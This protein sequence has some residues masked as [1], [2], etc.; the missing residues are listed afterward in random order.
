MD[1]II[2]IWVA[3]ATAL[4]IWQQKKKCATDFY[5][6][7]KQ[8]GWVRSHRIIR[9]TE[10]KIPIWRKENID[11][12]WMRIYCRYRRRWNALGL[13]NVYLYS[14]QL[15]TCLWHFET[16]R[17][18]DAVRSTGA[19]VSVSQNFSTK[20]YKI[21]KWCVRRIRLMVYFAYVIV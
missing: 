15:Y 7:R 5:W 3:D 13:S 18:F 20:N 10:R 17:N 4:Q 11:S 16:K 2:L 14:V 8:T 6:N 21:R 19:A 1:Y 12:T 9:E